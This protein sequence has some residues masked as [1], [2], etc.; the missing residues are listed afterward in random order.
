MT[1]ASLAV[2]ALALAAAPARAAAAR[3]VAVVSQADEPLRAAVER[4]LSAGAGVTL[5]SFA[6]ADLS[7]PIKR[8]E[9]LARLAAAD[10]VVPV[11]DAATSLVLEEVEDTP[12][13]F[14]G[15]AVVPGRRLGERGVSG[16]LAYDPGRLLDAAAALWRGKLGLAYT[17]GYES[18]AGA[19]GEAAR[20]RGLEVEQKRIDS[21]KG[22]P[23]ALGGLLS[24]CKAVWLLGDPLLA[25]GAGFAYASERS[26]SLKIPLISVDGWQVR[27]GAFLG[28]EPAGEPL[29]AAAAGELAA[30]EAGGHGA[31]ARVKPGPGAAVLVN[32]A[33]SRGWGVKVPSEAGW[34]MLP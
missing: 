34:R 8:G 18:L 30:L 7:D 6:R 14:V 5:L 2:L 29:A 20:S 3:R 15:A 10:L 33:L 31:G 23:A 13:Y 32:G 11:G 9:L 16:M 24:R 22:I 28:S 4:R 27:R 25:R 21:A 17:P 1:A 19:I 26:L 12:V